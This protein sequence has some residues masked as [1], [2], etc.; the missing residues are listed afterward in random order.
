MGCNCASQEQI[1]KLHTLYGEKITPSNEETLKFK[2][3]NFIQSLGV[4]IIMIILTPFFGLFILY[5]AIS[6]DKKVSIRKV[7]GL[8]KRNENLERV[9]AENILKNIERNG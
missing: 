4:F 8:K 7:L 3:K 5:K 2:L 1:K 6:R 9:F